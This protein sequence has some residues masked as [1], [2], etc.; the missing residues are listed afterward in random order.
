MI[1]MKMQGTISGHI[2][3]KITL[4]NLSGNWFKTYIP[5]FQSVYQ[6]HRGR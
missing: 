5:F 2:T 6:I 1:C 4:E 3:F